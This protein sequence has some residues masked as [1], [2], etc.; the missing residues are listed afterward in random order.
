MIETRS[1]KRLLLT[2][3]A[4]NVL[5]SQGKYYVCAALG[6][7]ERLLCS[8]PIHGLRRLYA[9]LSLMSRTLRLEPRCAAWVNGHQF[10]VT[11]QGAIWRIDVVSGKVCM[12]HRFE[13]GVSAPLCFCTLQGLNGFPDGILYGTYC[14]RNRNS[15]VCI[16]LRTDL[17]EWKN[18]YAFPRGRVL[19]IHS[20][21]PDYEKNRLLVLTG[22]SDSESG[23]WEFRGGFDAP[24][25]LLGGSQQYRTCAA[26]PGNG[27]ILFAT[28]TPLEQNWLYDYNE[29]TGQVQSIYPLPG[30]VICSGSFI[31]EGEKMHCFSTSVEPD[32]RKRGLSYLL[33]RR[34]G[35]GVQTRESH[36]FA[37]NRCR[38]F[39]EICMFRKDFL[40]MALCGFGNTAFPAG[41]SEHLYLCP[42]NTRRYNG[43]TLEVTL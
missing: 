6:E 8:A 27:H 3:G 34:L 23:I 5:Y 37:G 9:K 7:E 33:T 16:W 21:I 40:P 12:E 26:F 28:D 39:R 29:V 36:V 2:G 18:V 10:V 42:Q 30:P 11:Q 1:Q 19:H 41:E 22:D 35:P 38:G 17:A 31:A 20:L 14:G 15:T 32:S 13:S 24:R 43:K 25:L 4:V